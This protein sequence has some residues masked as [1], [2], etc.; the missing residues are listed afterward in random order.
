LSELN[1]EKLDICLSNLELL[2]SAWSPRSPISKRPS[3]VL[4]L[5]ILSKNKEPELLLL[6]RSA[7]VGTHKGQVGFPGGKVE[8][9]DVSPVETALREAEEEIGLSQKNI[10]AVGSLSVAVAIDGSAV[11]P[12]VGII[13]EEHCNITLDR[14]EVDDVYRVPIVKILE[15]NQK[16]FRFNMFGY[17]RK[18]FLYDCGTVSV[19]G[20]SAEILSRLNLK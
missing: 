9:Q 19:W 15:S 14:S 10:K 2:P 4:I 17:W 7:N 11:Y 1:T 16:N 6:R 8:P 5:F 3:A 12:I 18:S 20:L 13:A